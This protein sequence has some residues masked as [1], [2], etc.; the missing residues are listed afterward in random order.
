VTTSEGITR[1]KIGRHRWAW[2]RAMWNMSR[3]GFKELYEKLPGLKPIFEDI[4]RFTGG[5]PDILS[6]FY[7]YNWDVESVIKNIIKSKKLYSFIHSLS[8]EEKE[9][10]IRAVEDPDTLFT[11][12]KISLLNKLVELNLIVDDIT[13]RDPFLWIDIPPSERDL[14]LGIGK[15]VAWQ[16]PLHREAVK[17]TFTTLKP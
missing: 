16:T 4:W 9:W 15:Y 5:N 2:L 12:E 1:T 10:L 11:R 7:Q 6:Q 17:R 14:E 13:L 8:N 3:E